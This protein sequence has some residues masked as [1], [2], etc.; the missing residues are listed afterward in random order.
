MWTAA[1]VERSDWLSRIETLRRYPVGGEQVVLATL[2]DDAKFAVPRGVTVPFN[3]PRRER[4]ALSHT[5]E[6][7]VT[8]LSK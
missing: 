3:Q 7:S 1:V 6:V 2:V 8:L 5:T 4:S